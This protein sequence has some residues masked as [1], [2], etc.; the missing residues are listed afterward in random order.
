MIV[1]IVKMTFATDK[2]ADFLDVFNNAKNKILNCKGCKHLELLRD[3]NQPNVFFTHSHWESVPDLQTYRNSELFKATW[4]KTKI[5]FAA[6]P[7][8]WSLER[9]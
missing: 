7:E 2:V 5:L 3:V 4:A 6:S 1:R 9:V 8:A